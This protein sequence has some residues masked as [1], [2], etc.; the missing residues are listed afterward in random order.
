VKRIIQDYG[1]VSKY[2]AANVFVRA[3]KKSGLAF[4]LILFSLGK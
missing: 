4:V 3:R 2:N 1:R